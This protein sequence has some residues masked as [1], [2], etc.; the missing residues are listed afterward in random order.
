MPSPTSTMITSSDLS[1]LY[2]MRFASV[3]YIPTDYNDSSPYKKSV[4]DVTEEARYIL[5]EFII[6]RATEDGI[7]M[8]LVNPIIDIDLTAL[9]QYRQI[10]QIAHRL[11]IIGDEL[12][13]DE[14]IKN[15]VDQVPINSPYETF[16]DV[17]KEL[18]CDGI[19]NWGRIVT[20]F[21]FTYKLILKSLKDQPSAILHILVEWTV[22]FVKEIVAPWIVGKGGWLVILRD[23][24]PQSRF[25]TI[26]VFLSGMIA[27]FMVLYYF[28]RI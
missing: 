16:S 21:Y 23:A 25:T 11:R 13:A 7:D 9:P 4:E 27:T 10:Q 2:S 18:F 28:R 8:G 19:Y 14:R 1:D 15:M 26:G 3:P 12:D 17:A 6:E 22:R 24:V 5:E 20:L